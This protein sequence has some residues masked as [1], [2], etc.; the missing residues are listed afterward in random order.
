[1]MED[2]IRK[3]MYINICMTGSLCCMTEN[4]T[5]ESNYILI[6]VKLKNLEK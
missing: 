6:K 3:R 4:D 2:S 5:L 1:M